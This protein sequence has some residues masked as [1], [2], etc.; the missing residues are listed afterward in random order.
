MQKIIFLFIYFFSFTL[1]AQIEDPVEWFFSVE[2]TSDGDFNLIIQADIEKGWHVYSQH[3]DDDG[4]VPTIFQFFGDSLAFNLL[5]GVTE[6]NTITKFDPMFDMELSYFEN[7]ALFEQKIQVLNDTLNVIKGELEFM[8]C[9]E[10]MCLPPD[11]IDM[12]FEL[13]KKGNI[14]API[15]DFKTANKDNYIIPTID[16]NNP[17]GDCGE[18]K[19]EQSLWGVFLLGII[20]GFIALLTPCV[21]PMIPLTVSFFTKGANNRSKAIY[22]A[23][24]YGFFIFFTYTLL[25]LPFHLI[26]NINPEVLNQISTSPLLNV[27]F[28]IIFTVFAFSFFGYYELTLPSRWSTSA[29]TGSNMGGV[30]GIFFMALTLAIVSFSCTGPI[31]GSLLAGTL[32]SATADSLTIFGLDIAIVSAKLTLAMAGFGLA[33]G[34]PF[35]L[36]AAFPTWLNSLPKSGGWL[37]TV[38]VVL[39]FLEIALAIKFLSNADLVEQWG[40]IKREVFFALWLI[41]FSGLLLYILGF[42]KFPHD[43]PNTKL[44]NSRISFGFVIAGFILYLFPGVIGQDWW[45]HK[46]LSGFPPPK[47]YAYLNHDHNIKNIFHNYD[48][49]VEYAKINNKPIM[50]DFT[51]WACVNCRKIEDDVWS[52]KEVEKLLNENYVVI[53]LYV[54]EKTLLPHDKQEVVE[55]ITKDGKIKKKKIRRVGDKWSTLQSLTFQ[56]NSQPLHVVINP[57]EKLLGHPIGYSYARDS[58]NYIN[59]LQC[60]LDA[61]NTAQNKKK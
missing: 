31:L 60:G 12:V 45:S 52:E 55:I 5:G 59:Y 33:L 39:G 34:L 48:E 41:T 26:P 20:G 14:I 44:T 3:I 40:V 53:S 9:N 11:Y 49:G 2:N 38:K 58:N 51:G 36:F 37:N 21:F 17:L 46:L 18:K 50:I 7:K 8:V 54:D 27:V 30:L 6:S 4:P 23:L 57:D 24:L 16:L 47:Y 10:V 13:K 61:F 43:N 19:S 1:S 29:G 32:S 22:N 56:N 35:A 42:I 25:S 28:F 15:Q